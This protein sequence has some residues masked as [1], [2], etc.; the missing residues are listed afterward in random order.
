MYLP[1]SLHRPGALAHATGH[2]DAEAN[3]ARHVGLRVYTITRSVLLTL[4]FHSKETSFTYHCLPRK[5]PYQL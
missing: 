4:A 2:A 1:A 5:A 3:T